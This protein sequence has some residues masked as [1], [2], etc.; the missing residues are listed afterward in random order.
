MHKKKRDLYSWDILGISHTGCS[1]KRL[2][3]IER[4]KRIE[5][6]GDKLKEEIKRRNNATENMIGNL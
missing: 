1:L 2:K 4:L 5:V 3:N 6:M